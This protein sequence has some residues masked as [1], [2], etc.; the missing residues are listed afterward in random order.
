MKYSKLLEVSLAAAF[1]AAGA[2]LAACMPVSIENHREGHVFTTVM[3]IS[4]ADQQNNLPDSSVNDFQASVPLSFGGSSV[5]LDGYLADARTQCGG[6]PAHYSFDRVTVSLK[7]A[8]GVESLAKLVDIQLEVWIGT[9]LP[10]GG[11]ISDPIGS[12][13]KGEKEF[14]TFT[15]NGPTDLLLFPT[16]QN[17]FSILEWIEDG[18]TKDPRLTLS[19]IIEG[20]NTLPKTEDWSA[21]L[22]V[23]TVI[24]PICAQ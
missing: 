24:T 16:L 2:H 15:N 8:E 11:Y 9:D 5:D 18:E 7:H 1:A 6:D 4:S 21:D 20:K 22:V 19:L 12:S 10:G 13:W 17:D 3:P 23:Q 14:V